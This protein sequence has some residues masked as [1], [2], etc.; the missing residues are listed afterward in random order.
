MV[1]KMRAADEKGRKN[2]GRVNWNVNKG[3]VVHQANRKVRRSGSSHDIVPNYENETCENY[4]PPNFAAS[5]GVGN[6]T[7]TATTEDHAQSKFQLVVSPPGMSDGRDVDGEPLSLIS[8]SQYNR[9]STNHRA[10]KT[11]SRT[12]FQPPLSAKSDSVGH[13]I[14]SSVATQSFFAGT[15]TSPVTMNSAG[16]STADITLTPS[17]VRNAIARRKTSSSSSLGGKSFHKLKGLLAKT[18]KGWSSSSSSGIQ[19]DSKMLLDLLEGRRASGNF[20]PIYFVP[21]LDLPS[22]SPESAFSQE[23]S[24]NRVR[25]LIGEAVLQTLILVVMKRLGGLP[26]QITRIADCKS[27]IVRSLSKHGFKDWSNLTRETESILRYKRKNPSAEDPQSPLAVNSKPLDRPGIQVSLHRSGSLE[28]VMESRDLKNKHK[29]IVST[30]E[31]RKGSLTNNNDSRQCKTDD[32]VDNVALSSKEEVSLRKENQTLLKA[33]KKSQEEIKRLA[34]DRSRL[35]EGLDRA[36]SHIRQSSAKKRQHR[37]IATAE[38]DNVTTAL[39]FSSPERSRVESKATKPSHT[40]HVLT[41]AA[42]QTVGPLP[43][44]KSDQVLDVVETNFESRFQAVSSKVESMSSMWTAEIES[45]K[46]KLKS[47]TESYAALEAELDTCRNELANTVDL[48]AEA[49]MTA[50]KSLLQANTRQQQA[51]AA[52]EAEFR[53]CL[54]LTRDRI[55]S[56]G[57]LP[58]SPV[59]QQSACSSGKKSWVPISLSSVSPLSHS[60]ADDVVSPGEGGSLQAE[61]ALFA[62]QVASVCQQ[63]SDSGAAEAAQLEET[64]RKLHMALERNGMLSEDLREASR[65]RQHDALMIE[66]LV[67]DARGNELRMHQIELERQDEKATAAALKENFESLSI[68]LDHTKSSLLE[69]KEVWQAWQDE[70]E[71]ETGVRIAEAV[72]KAVEDVQ[73]KMDKA[74]AG[75]IA[76]LSALQEQIADMEVEM[77]VAREHQKSL[78]SDLKDASEFARQKNSE[79]EILKCSVSAAGEDEREIL[80]TEMLTTMDTLKNKVEEGERKHSMLE[81]A[82]ERATAAREQAESVAIAAENE[83]LSLRVALKNVERQKEEVEGKLREIEMKHS[84]SES[85]AVLLASKAEKD[86]AIE[87]RKVWTQATN[88]ERKKCQEQFEIQLAEEIESAVEAAIRVADENLKM[89]VQKAVAEVKAEKDHEREIAITGLKKKLESTIQEY[90]IRL[91]KAIA[92]ANEK[93]CEE[94]DISVEEAVAAANADKCEEIKTAVEEAIEVANAQKMEEIQ[95]A[96]SEAVADANAKKRKEIQTAVAE[97]IEVANSSKTE[98]IE[99]AIR[100]AVAATNKKRS[101]EVIKA[102]FA[103]KI[104]KNLEIEHAKQSAVSE[105]VAV[106]NARKDAEIKRAVESGVAN[107]IADNNLKKDAEIQVIVDEE[108]KK[109]LDEF[110]VRCESQREDMAKQL[111]D[112]IS[113][114]EARLTISKRVKATELFRVSVLRKQVANKKKMMA[115]MKGHYEMLVHASEMEANACKLSL[116]NFQSDSV[117]KGKVWEA[118][119]LKMATELKR[120]HAELE[121]ERKIEWDERLSVEKLMEEKNKELEKA[122]NAAECM[123]ATVESWEAKCL[124]LNQE[125]EKNTADAIKAAL[126][127]ARSTFELE[128]D[129]C[130]KKSAEDAAS[131]FQEMENSLKAKLLAIEEAHEQE[132]EK[133]RDDCDAREDAMDAQI[134]AMSSTIQEKDSEIATANELLEETQKR[135]ILAESDLADSR[136]DIQSR[137]AH[138]SIEVMKAK[139]ALHACEA[140]EAAAT[141]RAMAAEAKGEECARMAEDAANQL[142]KALLRESELEREVE[143]VK[144]RA[145]NAS[146]DA[147]AKL[148]AGKN[149]VEKEREKG[150]A[151]L[152]D[153]GRVLAEERKCVARE[154]ALAAKARVHAEQAAENATKEA[155]A[156]WSVKFNN[157]ASIAQAEMKKLEAEARQQRKE[158]LAALEKMMRKRE[159]LVGQ[160]VAQKEAAWKADKARLESQVRKVTLAGELAGKEIQRLRAAIASKE[161]EIAKAAA[162]TTRLEE[163]QSENSLPSSKLESNYSKIENIS[164]V[165]LKSQ[166]LS[167]R[168]QAK[169]MEGVAALAQAQLLELNK[170]FDVIADQAALATSKVSELSDEASAT[171]K[172]LCVPSTCSAQVDSSIRRDVR[173]RY[174]TPQLCRAINAVHTLRDALETTCAASKSVKKSSH[175]TEM[176]LARAKEQ[177]RALE[178]STDSLKEELLI[179]RQKNTDLLRQQRHVNSTANEIS[180]VTPSSSPQR[181]SVP[182]FRSPK[183]SANTQNKENSFSAASTAS[184][185]SQICKVTPASGP[186]SSSNGSNSSSTFTPYESFTPLKAKIA[187]KMQE[188]QVPGAKRQLDMEL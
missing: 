183:H 33:L 16:T 122:V 66:K 114:L 17:S 188:D 181:G 21:T 126:M 10:T 100:I 97:A 75:Y 22:R 157:A 133:C 178:A 71:E 87:S 125:V 162:V 135:L 18:W 117:R 36:S 104:A 173:S 130:R 77:G 44:S 34:D 170:Q 82:V 134:E 45:L 140:R 37:A 7:V 57:S 151:V 40:A 106:L 150:A 96:V 49:R 123:R 120:V 185:S 112:K 187:R 65:Q 158:E 4:M 166:L 168:R 147:Q 169:K 182:L 103:A 142:D 180:M 48:V 153:M 76:E 145:E 8:P 186:G 83:S 28:V 108:V 95:T 54:D 1:N 179:V 171:P 81:A 98:E 38:K 175:V 163:Q 129:D 9:L 24:H 11:S 53:A 79:L 55:L 27:R 39:I 88:L 52:Q 101:K 113:H 116:E 115:D 99:E 59:G 152:A 63:L 3:T 23:E 155:N 68:E 167:A 47:K 136:K 137:E 174:A 165:D 110:R 6:G 159:A 41:A 5:S 160:E 35:I 84:I 105:I 69:Q 43:N 15:N 176:E 90:D 60:S 94:I 127:K 149:A 184:S 62:D 70:E 56:G 109:A 46:A 107:A 111:T 119:R 177:C 13:S 156:V 61:V 64:K 2:V 132:L 29:I 138:L 154:K 121:L 72:E 42:S 74:K 144:F 143:E 124:Q 148:T 86:K 93:R 78:E 12:G 102:L 58:T 128:L 164:E 14:G 19:V 91:E 73:N 89:S 92:D 26:S 161:D 20:E 51:L 146:R 25:L 172:N 30:D 85:E 131:S 80:R 139:E 141:A 118:E 50:T 31:A 32:T 67:K